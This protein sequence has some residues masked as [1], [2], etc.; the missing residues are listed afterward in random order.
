MV[1]FASPLIVLGLAALATAV[2]ITWSS[3]NQPQEVKNH[4]NCTF[5]YNPEVL[6]PWFLQMQNDQEAM[7]A[8]SNST[9]TGQKNAQGFEKVT[10]PPQSGA[11]AVGD[12][13]VDSQGLQQLMQTMKSRVL[14]SQSDDPADKNAG[15]N[16]G[17]DQA[18]AQVNSRDLSL[19]KSSRIQDRS[20]LATRGLGKWCII[21]TIAAALT[22]WIG[23]FGI[24]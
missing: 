20:L 1:R 9:M 17:Q 14:G 13:W 23:G 19:P 2:E 21:A 15:G 7:Q 18:P 10:F 5:T 3:N 22:I 4:I 16:H 12:C 11:K 8:M 6:L 24:L